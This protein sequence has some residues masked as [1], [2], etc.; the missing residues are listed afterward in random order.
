LL[1]LTYLDIDNNNQAA[2]CVSSST[3]NLTGGIHFSAAA[4]I[5]FRAY[6]G[7]IALDSGE[8]FLLLGE[9]PNAIGRLMVWRASRVFAM[10]V[11]PVDIRQCT[12]SKHCQ[13]RRYSPGL[14][15]PSLC[16]RNFS[17]FLQKDE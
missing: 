9:N 3:L 17:K 4:A 2:V 13:L 5:D 7:E 15:Y 8:A 16:P 10:L 6:S 12:R 14:F 11:S 1:R